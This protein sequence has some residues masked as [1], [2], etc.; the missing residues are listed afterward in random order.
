MEIWGIPG[1]VYEG[2]E[3]ELREFCINEVYGRAAEIAG[4]HTRKR[5]INPMSILVCVM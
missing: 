3:I 5:N 4:I 1:F 2:S